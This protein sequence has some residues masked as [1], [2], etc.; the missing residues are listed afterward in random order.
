MIRKRRTRIVATLGP[1]SR[2]P[3]Q[4]IA[5]ARAYLNEVPA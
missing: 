2:E 1:A 4:V 5:L 3:D